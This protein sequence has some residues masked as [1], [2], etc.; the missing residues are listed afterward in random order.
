MRLRSR[1]LRCA[2]MLATLMVAVLL[3]VVAAACSSSP[4]SAPT[5]SASPSLPQVVA[6]VSAATPQSAFNRYL[7]DRLSHMTA[8]GLPSGSWDFHRFGPAS[9]NSATFELT[10]RFTLENPTRKLDSWSTYSVA[11]SRSGQPGTV[12]RISPPAQRVL[13]SPLWTVGP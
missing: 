9:S 2:R 10:V 4:S 12:A 3:A 6:T 11:R 8:P 7:T 5:A 13:P 1:S